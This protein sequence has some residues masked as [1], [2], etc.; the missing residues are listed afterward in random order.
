[1]ILISGSNDLNQTS[2]QAFQEIDQAY[3]VKPY[4]KYSV[5]ITD[6]RDIPYHVH[7]AVKASITGRPGPVYLDLPG[8]VLTA[9]V[10]SEIQYPLSVSPPL[11]GPDVNEIESAVKL[12]SQHK[13]PLVIVGKGCSYGRAENEVRQFINSTGIPFLPTPMGKGV[14]QDSHE[15]N[16]SA[17]RSTALKEA[18]LVILLGA[19]LN[20]ILHFGLPPRFNKNVKLIQVDIS[21][22]E[23]G[24]NI[25]ASSRIVG[26]MRLCMNELNKRVK[27]KIDCQE[28]CGKL[29]KISKKN[30]NLNKDLMADPVV[31]MTYYSSYEVINRFIP[32][33]TILVGEGANT[34][35][36]GRTVFEHEFPRRKLDAATFG[37]MGIGLPAVVSARTC[38][39]ELWCVAVM[40]DSAFGFSAME[41]ETLTRYQLG[42]TIFIINNNGIYSG[43]DELEGDPLTYGVTH[44]NPDAKYQ[45][46]AEA[47]GGKGFEAKTKSDLEKICTEIF[48]SVENKNKLFIINV[49]IQPSSSKKPQENE[50]LTRKSPPPKL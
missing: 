2:K 39:P 31:P 50:W 32:K 29:N 17:A 24:H 20:W 3:F 44:L 42:A 21:P 40:G 16:I 22:E 4:V 14:V 26:D 11:Y 34:M 37:T 1:M 27:G 12:L 43:T 30:K 25:E 23:I 9:T 6:P 45:V 49:R 7:K 13:N 48:S 19:R 35:D 28:W 47:F 15:L 41:C 10:E 36:I 8:D 38:N 5:R 18:D 33:E 46:I